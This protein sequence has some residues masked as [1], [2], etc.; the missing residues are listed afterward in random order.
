MRFFFFR[1]SEQARQK[2][3]ALRKVI[4]T[5]WVCCDIFIIKVK[6]KTSQLSVSV[7]HLQACCSNPQWAKLCDGRKRKR[8]VFGVVC[9]CVCGEVKDEM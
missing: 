1:K 3:S 4:A 6:K 9:V 2:C 7:H 8:D 5:H